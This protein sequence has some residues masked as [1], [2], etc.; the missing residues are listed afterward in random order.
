M[1]SRLEI[2]LKKELVDAEGR[3]LIRKA[4]DYF[5][6]EL[7]D[8]RVIK[9]LT[10]DADLDD[11]QL[12][13]IRRE[14][15]TNPVTEESSFSPIAKGFDWL[16][17]I[18]F[19]PGVR[20]TAGSTA[21]EA[22]EDLLNSRFKSDESVY[23]SKLY[24]IRGRISEAQAGKIAAEILANDIIQQ[25]RLYSKE[26]WNPVEG[27][28]HTV[29][30]VILNHVPNVS[31]IDIG[32]DEELRL[33]SRKRNLALQDSDI[34]II[35]RYFLR[36]D[37]LRQRKHFGLALPTD[38]ELEYISQ[39]R[40]DHCNHNTFKGL[41]RY[42]DVSNGYETIVDNLFKTCIEAPTLAIKEKKEWVVSV[43]W[44]NAGVARFDD[45]YYYVITGE[46]HNSPSNMEAYGGALTGIVGIYRDIM[47]TGK[48]AKLILGM[49]GY[50]V[51]HRDYDGK[52]MP[53]LHPRR[54]L[55]GI[56]EGVKDG[57]NKS[58]VPTPFGQVIFDNGFMGKCL[59]FLTAM[60]IMPATVAGESSHLK[61][62]EPGDLI[63]MAGGR[64]GKDGI[65][66]VTAASETYTENTP[67][68]HVQIGDPY[69][70]KK[71]HDFLLEARD[72]GIISFITDNGGGGLSSSIGESARFS[73]GCRVDLDK[74]PLKYA[75]LDQWEIWVSE[76]QERMTIGIKPERLDR[77]ME[78]SGMHAVEST[79]IG[80]YNDSGY[81]RLDYKGRTC[82]LISMDFMKSDFPQWEFDAEWIP[83]ELR[84]LREPVLSEPARHGAVLRTILS[85]PNIC[86]KNWIA[87]QYDH[88]VQGG[89][90]IK[91]LVGKGRDMPGD[92]VVV[93]PLLGVDR[94]IVA[95]QTMNPFYSEIDTYHMTAVTIDEA[96]RKVLAVGGD[97][98]HL[99]GVD[100][101]CWPTIQYH[102]ERNPDGKYKAAQLVRANWALRD[103]CLSYGIPLLSGKDSMYIDGNLEGP[104][105][106]RRKVSGMPTLLFTVSSVIKDIKKCVTM[107]V[108][109]PGD[110]IYMLGR[111]KN[112]LGG[113]EYY[114]MMGYI[115]LNVPK[116]D[117]KECF[118]LYLKFHEA[119]QKGLISSAHAVTRGGLAVNLALAAMG[120]ETGMEIRLG[121]V[122][123]DEDLSDSMRLYSES[124]GRFV[125][126]I[127]P[128][129]K[130][131][132]EKLFAGMAIGCI[133]V[134][135][136]SSS[137]KIYGRDDSVIIEEEIMVLKDCWKEL[138]GGLI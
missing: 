121:N 124:A 77:F 70:Q 24:E 8:V 57:G 130:D 71:M 11:N 114:Q 133:G 50:C 93:M 25:Y 109:V 26:V 61:M 9:V 29:P 54:L 6:F 128:S 23:T 4:K 22:I 102:P 28:G 60:G 84:G 38:V 120:G 51:G 14:I 33:I 62:T 132:F 101:F 31:T 137:L 119:V 7:E 86:A 58:G 20:D 81:L 44:D 1:V 21:V 96:V 59:V 66:G 65:H 63:I 107:D 3:N 47:G 55:D 48:G 76:S 78:L 115:G 95:S 113:S 126:T 74:V 127:D 75:G 67:A 104:H 99:G 49:Y 43:L 72:E 39:A 110:L 30:K 41:F 87:R 97:P 98:E 79:V 53:R 46:T 106:E 80:E 42:H 32:S 18:G 2:R 125:V 16:I 37:M 56:I 45:N 129:R 92:A 122:P 118:P 27:I 83:P 68:G 123:S 15:F 52:L 131:S 10:I 12:E 94:G 82:A 91:P 117:A 138:F 105:G 116:V 108:S 103:Y 136:E 35:R 135:T 64:V 40:S 85:R 69:T 90:V 34:R 111:T 73:N 36:K 112:E 13:M 19:R 134:V 100:N 89:C 88:E 17:W 5:G